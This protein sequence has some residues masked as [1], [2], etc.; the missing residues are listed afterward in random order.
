LDEKGLNS[1][2][3]RQCSSDWD[4]W[5]EDDGYDEWLKK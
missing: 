3:N 5:N 4:G 1:G 2:S